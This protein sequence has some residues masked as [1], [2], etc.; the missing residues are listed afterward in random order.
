MGMLHVCLGFGETEQ[1]LMS[2]R[3]GE[4]FNLE[5]L[6]NHHVEVLSLFLLLIIVVKPSSKT[7]RDKKNGEHRSSV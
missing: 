3:H 6:R 1:I 2:K 7:P 5:I 4:I